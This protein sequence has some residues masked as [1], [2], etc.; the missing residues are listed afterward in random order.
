MS[1]RGEVV[2]GVVDGADVEV[3]EVAEMRARVT[4]RRV[5]VSR[6]ASHPAARMTWS[7]WSWWTN[8]PTSTPCGRAA[9]E[10]S[11]VAK[12][13]ALAVAEPLGAVR[14]SRRTGAKF[15]GVA[16]RVV[17]VVGGAVAAS[18]GEAIRIEAIQI[19]VTAG[20]MTAG[21]IV[22][23]VM[24]T[25]RVTTI[26]RGVSMPPS[27]TLRETTNRVM[28]STHRLSL[29]SLTGQSRPCGG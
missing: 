24:I 7:K 17:A 12:T 4:E 10:R 13:G 1:S 22:T 8:R 9:K 15:A 19:E 26:D 29:R 25:V 28:S 14:A 20:V 5:G 16:V 11:R 6:V 3:V 21:V 18:K 27:S 23:G 2:H